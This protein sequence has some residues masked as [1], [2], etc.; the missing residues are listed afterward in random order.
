MRYTPRDT[1]A[2]KDLKKDT[3][4]KSPCSPPPENS[5]RGIDAA[6]P[7]DWDRLRQQAPAIEPREEKT[8]LEAWAVTNVSEPSH[9][10]REGGIECIDVM[11]S[12]FGEERVKDWAEITAFKYQWRQ[13]TKAGNTAE[14]DKLKSIWYT[15]FSMGDDPRND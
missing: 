7:Q 15:R 10:I 5:Y 14:Q 4:T 13:G 2:K 12:L 8:G 3:E 9:Y 6:T 1:Q 11:T